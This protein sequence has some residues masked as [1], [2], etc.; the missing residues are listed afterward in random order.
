MDRDFILKEFELI[1][2]KFRHLKLKFN[3]DNAVI[4]GV[5]SF[6]CNVKNAIIRDWFLIKINVPNTF[7]DALPC[8]EE[9]D[10]RIP[11]ISSCHVNPDGTLCLGIPL[12]IYNE[13]QKNNNP[14]FFYVD[15]Y[16]VDFLAQYS[17]Y[18]KKH[19]WPYGEYEHGGFGIL[20]YYLQ[21]F[22]VQSWELVYILL[23]ILAL[24]IDFKGNEKC[25]C[26]SNKLY[27]NCHKTILGK[28]GKTKYNFTEDL[29]LVNEYIKKNLL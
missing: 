5:I 6:T 16:I 2:K 14:L 19:F 28:L 29:I 23:K 3:G 11:R 15:T 10:N 20:N 4:S 18:E 17:F 8:V 25:P 22:K 27:K 9:I 1:Q 12:E 26:G 21:E 24:N 7:P 13:I